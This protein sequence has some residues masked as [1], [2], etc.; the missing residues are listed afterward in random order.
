MG[1]LYLRGKT[2]W[3]KH[4]MNGRPIRESTGTSKLREAERFLKDREGRVVQGAPILPRLDRIRFA[5]AAEDLLE[6]YQTTGSRNMRDVNTKM[7]PLRACFDHIRLVNI[8]AASVTKYV[9]QRQ[10]AGLANG[11][12]NRELSILGKAL[13]LAQERGQLVKVP[14]IHLLQE[15]SPRKGFFE[16]TDFDRV[17]RQLAD[18]PDLI[19]AISIMY[20]YGWRVSEVLGLTLAQIDLGA[21]TIRLN[22]G[23]TKNREGR[24]VYMTPEIETLL[25][26]QVERVR[27]MSATLQRIIPHLFFNPCKGRFYG[28][29]LKSFRKTW[30]LACRQAQV[31]GMLLHDFRRSAV[32]NLLRSGT[33]EAICMKVTGHRT[34]SVFDR[35]AIVNDADLKEAA[36]K[37][38]GTLMGTDCESTLTP[39]L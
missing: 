21:K 1:M 22:P 10:A 3:I 34:R 37:L 4:Y 35:Y 26:R 18:R 25:I 7:K 2:Y 19:A 12:I 33:P 16:K 32:R 39:A 9:N 17:K 29:R 38:A 15:A 5:E 14:K 24:V 20:T 6:H 11:T 28:D 8:D 13:R 36:R 23:Q 31:P 27:A 30:A